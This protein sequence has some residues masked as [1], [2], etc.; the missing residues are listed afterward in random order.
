M[1]TAKERQ[2]ETLERRVKDLK[3]HNTLLLKALDEVYYTYSSRR[4]DVADTIADIVN[5]DYEFGEAEKNAEHRYIHFHI[6]GVEYLYD[7]LTTLVEFNDPETGTWQTLDN[8]TY[9]GDD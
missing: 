7:T 8:V 9:S 4:S 6:N 1:S 3:A 2:V 5:G